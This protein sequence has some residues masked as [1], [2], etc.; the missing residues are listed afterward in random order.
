M[1][2]GRNNRISNKQ[3]QLGVWH[4]RRWSGAFVKVHWVDS[5]INRSYTSSNTYGINIAERGSTF[6]SR[7]H[8]HTGAIRSHLRPVPFANSLVYIC[9]RTSRRLIYILL[10]VDLYAVGFTRVRRSLGAGFS[11][12]ASGRHLSSFPISFFIP[13]SCSNLH[14]SL[15]NIYFLHS[16]FVHFGFIVL[17]R[18]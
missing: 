1:Y 2:S 6:K 4:G 18:L 3:R 10:S 14:L 17:W 15:I 8:F 9:P 11:S 12:V 16:P 7:S 13:H 5:K